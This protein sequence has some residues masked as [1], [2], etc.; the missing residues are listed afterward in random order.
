MRNRSGNHKY[1]PR[2]DAFGA[3]G[4]HSELLPRRRSADLELDPITDAELVVVS[5]VFGSTKMDENAEQ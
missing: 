4:M 5:P 1:D 2:K 3:G